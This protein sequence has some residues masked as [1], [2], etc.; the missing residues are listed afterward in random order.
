M[1]VLD[2]GLES[3][4]GVDVFWNPVGH[5]D[6]RFPD[7]SNSVLRSITSRDS[8][9]IIYPNITG[10][11]MIGIKEG[12]SD[13]DVREALHTAGLHNIQ[14]SDWFWTAECRPFIEPSICV[15][16]EMSIPFVKYAEPNSLQRLIDFGPGWSC[17]RLT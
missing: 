14:G 13:S 17:V 12:I 15:G 2:V 10:S 9:H 11:I 16:L 6:P 7:F 8:G 1:F 4:I 5:G 3:L